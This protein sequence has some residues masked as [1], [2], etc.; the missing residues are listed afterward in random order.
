MVKSRVVIDTNIIIDHLRLI[1]EEKSLFEICVEDPKIDPLIS[2]TT[3][4][5]LFVGQSSLKEEQEIKIRK[6][7]DSVRIAD[8]TAGIAQLAG[9]IMRDTK[10][11][12]QFSDAQIAATAILNK[13]S[14]LT[15]NKKDFKGIKGLKLI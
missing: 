5:E 15:L 3:I 7:L 14:L 8:I 6:I 2:T 12:V 4:Q 11:Q 1:R 10:P 13:A 9:Q